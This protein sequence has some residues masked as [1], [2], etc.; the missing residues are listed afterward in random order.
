VAQGLVQP[1]NL[2][3]GLWEGGRLHGTATLHELTGELE[4]EIDH[5]LASAAARPKVVSAL[6]GRV[7]SRC[8]DLPMTIERAGALSV[9]DRQLLMLRLGIL[10]EGDQVWLHP[11]CARCQSLFDVGYQR[12]QVPLR[13]AGAGYPFTTLELRS[14]RYRFR[15]PN[16]SDQEAIAPLTDG[17]ALVEMV[18]RCLTSEGG[19]DADDEAAAL[20]ASL[21]DAEREQLDRAM[22][23]IAPELGTT[24]TTSCPEC[25]AAAAVSLDPY[26]VRE[27]GEPRFSDLTQEIHTIALHYHWS[28]RDILGLTRDRRREYLLLIQRQQGSYE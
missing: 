3:G 24:I 22:E 2:P 1:V 26:E 13:A 7:V 28:E 5:L 23:G 12:S 6:L 17:E 21:T 9:A 10:L 8:G 25:G 11:T 15:V 19:V 16:G 4:R 18:R 14:R 20:A 27:P